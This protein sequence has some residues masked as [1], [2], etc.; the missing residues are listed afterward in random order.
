VKPP[1]VGPATLDAARA[2]EPDAVAA[3]YRA[4]SPELFRFFLGAVRNKETA[5]DLVA[6]VF[7]SVIEAL[8][9]FRGPADALP[10]WLFRIARHDLYDHRRR[11]AR[12]PVEP[13]DLHPELD[14]DQGA[15]G[16]RA[17]DPQEVVIGRMERGRLLDAMRRLPPLQRDVLL[18]RLIGGLPVQDV[19]ELVGRSPGAVKALQHR[20]LA[21]LSR[22][23]GPF[24]AR[25]T[26]NPPWRLP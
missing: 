15:P 25:A 18:L 4:H 9:R 12:Y 10:G 13:L 17:D 16:P 11:V 20:G 5:E 7:V 21:N 19:A 26:P 8:P 2:G 3:V 24:Q 14:D 23:A 22:L 6:G 1:K